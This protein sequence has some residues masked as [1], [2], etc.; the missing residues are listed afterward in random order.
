VDSFA[1]CYLWHNTMAQ[2]QPDL[3]SEAQKILKQNFLTLFK[4]K[5]TIF[6]Y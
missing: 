5:R 3:P 2:Q 4:N 1:M 6:Y